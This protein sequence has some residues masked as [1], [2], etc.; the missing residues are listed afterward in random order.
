MAELFYD[1]DADLSIIAGRKVA[2]IGYG[3]QGHAHALNLRDSGVDVRVGLRAGSA[4]I[5]K[6]EAE[7]LRVLPVVDAVKE[8]DVVVILAPDQ[9]QRHVY[10][11]EIAPNFAY[12]ATGGPKKNGAFVISHDDREGLHGW[13]QNEFPVKGDKYYHFHAARKATNVKVPRRSAVVRILWRDDAGKPVPLSEAPVKGYLK[14]FTGNAEAEHPT[15]KTT[16]ADG[17]TEVSDTYKAPA[18]ATTATRYARLSARPRPTG[19]SRSRRRCGSASTTTSSIR[20]ARSIRGFWRRSAA[21]SMPRG[22]SSDWV[23]R[24]RRAPCGA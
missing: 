5:A 24:P 7:G 14:G 2:V 4:S 22:R 11:D 9:V 15:D 23:C 12:D 10:R 19:C 17:W 16:D 1:D 13:L 3:S 8:A 21:S 18:K 6:A 20:A